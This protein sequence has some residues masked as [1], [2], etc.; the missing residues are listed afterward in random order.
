MSGYVSPGR[1]HFCGGDSGPEGVQSGDKR[2][3]LPCA[4]RVVA[5]LGRVYNAPEIGVLERIKFLRDNGPVGPKRQQES[6]REG[7]Y[8]YYIRV[9]ELIKIGYAGDV[10]KRMRNYPP[11]AELIAAHPGTLEV[12]RQMHTRFREYLARGREWFYPTPELDEHIAYVRDQ[13]GD[14]AELAY[15]FTAPKSQEE[16]VRAQMKPRHT[17]GGMHPVIG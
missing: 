4:W 10:G 9:G 2:L 5:D 1:C 15:S 17:I 8:V 14:P 7:G 6:K 11:N 12:E 13:F 16:R 3:C